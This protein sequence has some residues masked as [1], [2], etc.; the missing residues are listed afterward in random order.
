MSEHKEHTPKRRPPLHLPFE[1]RKV[2]IAV[3]CYDHRI[4]I[5][6][7]LIA[8]VIFGIVFT[9]GKISYEDRSATQSMIIDFMEEPKW[10]LTPE[11]QNILSQNR[12]DDFSDVRNA[13][14]NDNAEQLNS[15]L[16][17]DRGTQA[18]QLYEDAG[19]LDEAMNAN[20]ELYEAGL[21]QEQEILSQRSEEGGNEETQQNIQIKGNV[22][23]RFSFA[24]PVRNSV[25]LIVPAYLCEGGGTIE[26]Y[27]TLDNNGKVVATAV[28]KA[29]SS[30][31]ECM[32]MS[33]INAA[34]KSRFNVD[35]NAPSR[36]KGTITYTFI[37]Q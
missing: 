15:Q 8:Y 11:Q 29:A 19:K 3:W 27:V 34:E 25:N 5:C 30:A 7:T 14:S 6:I 16:R 9:V 4:G 22:T 1:N 23:V 10:E 33:A 17:D 37:P 21:M 20:R 31:D 36:H 28:N 12:N 35:P 32:Q 24:D 2:D 26:L 18:S 13:A